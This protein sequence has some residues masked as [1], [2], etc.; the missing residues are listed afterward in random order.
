MKAV[1]LIFMV[2]TV[3]FG[4]TKSYTAGQ[5]LYN[6][7]GC[8]NCHGTQG[9]GSGS[10]PKLA[11]RSKSY[12]LSKLKQF[13]QGIS[14]KQSQQVMFGFARSLDDKEMDE[15]TLF[16]SNYKEESNKK[17]KLNYGILGGDN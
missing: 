15:I 17:Y 2:G 6:D 12:L 9:E 14:T 3:L 11:H 7:K 4:A 1:I 5:A 13:K 16:L 8:S 10:F